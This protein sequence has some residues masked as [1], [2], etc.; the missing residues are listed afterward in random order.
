MDKLKAE[1]RMTL[2]DVA[3]LA[4]VQRPVVSMWRSRSLG[5]AT[6]FPA[7][8]SSERGRDLFS[9]AEIV[10]WLQ[11]TG[12]GNN[13][14][15]AGDVAAFASRPGAG[16][17]N[18][19][20]F[21]ALTACLALRSLEGTSLAALDRDELLDLADEH[22]P[23]DSFLY[24]ELE[25]APEVEAL[26]AHADVLVDSHY[27]APAAFEA[28]LQD[29]FRSGIREHASIALTEPAMDLVAALA[30]ELAAGFGTDPVF[31]DP[32]AGGSDLLLQIVQRI[33]DTRPVSVL[34][35]ED[36]RAAARLVRRRLLVH[37]VDHSVLA[38]RPE[39]I[40]EFEGPAVW[41]AQFPS[42]GAPDLDG[43]GI[44]NSIHRLVYSM[45]HTQWAV[46]IA[47]AA[48]LS[49]SLPRK[50]ELA[51]AELIRSSRVRAVVRLPQGL[52]R[53]KPRE[54]QALWVLGPQN[55][56]EIAE[57]WT[58]VADISV[59]DLSPAVSGNLVSDIVASAGSRETVRAHAFSYA[60][61][62][63]TR[64]LLARSGGLTWSMP[65]R[66]AVPENR[67][68]ETELRLEALLRRLDLGSELGRSFATAAHST[69]PPPGPV[70]V[71]DMLAAGHLKY[72]NGSRLDAADLNPEEP[73]G[74]RPPGL[75]VIG[76]PE[77]LDR[78]G[79]VPQVTVPQVV[80][81]I[82]LSRKYP[83]ARL[84][85]R[86]DIIFC[87]SPHP[88]AMVDTEGGSVIAFPA[89]I[90][91][92]DD[93]DPGGLSAAVVAADINSVP[94]ADKLWRQWR[95]RR[96]PDRQHQALAAVLGSLQ[97]E[98]ARARQRLEDLTE[99]ATLILDGVA[100]GSLAL[101]ETGPNTADPGTPA[102]PKEGTP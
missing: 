77:L 30:V 56:V 49:D 68:A 3:A 14:E 87:T 100:D 75:P 22:D 99:L 65:S 83:S 67:Q 82:G 92:I 2:S 47:P 25:T 44:L 91:R 74:Q 101:A 60:K 96:T 41:V 57:R 13:P 15:A 46:V 53:Q 98:R 20:D 71:Q 97:H 59:R 18:R 24:S 85:R 43:S 8:V 80:N 55:D 50:L 63:P 88:R 35:M 76:V 40:F 31:V 54:A 17:G 73:R 16:P 64:H 69:A 10:T 9:A 28:L 11:A 62:V 61:L 36:D 29:R 81:L 84:T 42:P 33:D 72:I 4:K 23:D 102:A 21:E 89:R 34:T 5:T 45:D 39:G 78:D 26:A 12:R 95:L 27:S 52:V 93:G 51:R 48:V 32:T 66:R 7:P 79:T 94:A 6:P 90:L 38:V 37:G 1:L 86:G 19:H 58:M 70:A